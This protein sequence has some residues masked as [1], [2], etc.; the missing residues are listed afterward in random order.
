VEEYFINKQLQ[1]A[2]RPQDKFGSEGDLI[3]F[4]AEETGA[5]G[6]IKTS[7]ITPEIS[8]RVKVVLTF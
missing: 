1:N 3:N 8:A 6:Y 4:V 7:S 2:E 5:I